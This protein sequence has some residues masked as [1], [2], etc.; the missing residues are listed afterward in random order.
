[1]PVTVPVLLP[2]DLGPG[3]RGAFTTR[4]GGV[5]W[6]RYDAPDATGGLNL[7]FHV[8]D[9]EDRVLANRDLLDRWAGSHVAWMSQRHGRQVRTVDRPPGTGRTSVGQCD[10]LLA[11]ADDAG[12]PAAV[13]VMVADCVPLLLATPSGDRVAAVHVGRQGLAADII[14]TVLDRLADDGAAPAT[15]YASLGPSICGRCYEVPDDLRT[16][17]CAVVPAA[18]ATTSWG[19]ASLDVAAGVRAQLAQRG[20]TRVEQ[21]TACTYEDPTFYSYRRDGTTGRFAGLVQRRR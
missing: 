2:A 3:A 4:A 15:L 13:A 5:S 16:E 12:A 21:H 11:R 9:D 7:G 1:M 10:A 20:L 8:G 17:V 19:T 18:F 14:G 6:G